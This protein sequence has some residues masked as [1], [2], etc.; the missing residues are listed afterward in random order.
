M[1]AHWPEHEK[2]HK[3][4]DKS[5]AIG[6]FLDWCAAE[7]GIVLVNQ[8]DYRREGIPVSFRPLLAEFFNID[9]KALEAE[10]VAML[11]QMRA[12]LGDDQ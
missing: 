2:L 7:K 5:Q 3:V 6:E 1:S 4:V 10:K 8:D 9:E 12:T 11:E